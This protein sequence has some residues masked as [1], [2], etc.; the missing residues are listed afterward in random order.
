MIWEQNSKAI[1]MLNRLVERGQ[2]KCHQY[3]PNGKDND[4][5]DELLF[6]DVK[7]KV[8]FI[9]EKK[10]HNYIFRKL[11]LIDTE[12][13]NGFHFDLYVFTYCYLER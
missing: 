6:T 2:I 11:L 1:L 10:F 7:L 12:V 3:W 5:N 8:E 4:D 13:I 9:S